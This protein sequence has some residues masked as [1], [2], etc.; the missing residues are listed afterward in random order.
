MNPNVGTRDINSIETCPV[1]AV[2][3]QVEYLTIGRPIHAKVGRGR[4]H[5]C[6]VMNT[7]AGYLEGMM[8]AAGNISDL[9]CI[10]GLLLR[11]V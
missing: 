8:S 10:M 6:Q 3:D 11:K 9:Y 7:E 1:T 4:V 5:Q 2:N